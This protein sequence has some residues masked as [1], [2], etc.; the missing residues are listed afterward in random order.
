MTE[1]RIPSAAAEHDPSP[2]P[3]SPPGS[4]PAPVAAPGEG[5]RWQ[6]ARRAAAILL[7]AR[8]RRPVPIGRPIQESDY[9]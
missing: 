3:G 8:S 9:R 2:Q 1:V 6:A 4:P 5:G 7:G